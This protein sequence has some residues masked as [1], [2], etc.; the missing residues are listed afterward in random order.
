MSIFDL[1]DH[2]FSLVRL[3]TKDNRE[4]AKANEGRRV[5]TRNEPVCPR[6]YP[7]VNYDRCPATPGVL[8]RPDGGPARG[9]EPLNCFRF[10]S[11]SRRF[12]SKEPDIAVRDADIA[13]VSF[14]LF[15][16]F[17]GE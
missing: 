2:S 1:H 8:Y 15:F 10:S 7:V 4:I 17:T 13:Q 3:V 16:F 6:N 9:H 14:S 5:G 11:L 12:E